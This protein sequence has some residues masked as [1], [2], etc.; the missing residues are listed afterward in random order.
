MPWPLLV[1]AY[2]LLV[3]VC[4]AA[5]IWDVRTGRIP[6]KL[7]YPALL[8]APVLWYAG[9]FLTAGTHEA[10]A[11]SGAS[12]VGLL[13]GGVP[14][15]LLVLTMGLGGGDMKLMAAVG[16]LS[17]SWPV[18]LCTTVYALGVAVIMALG[19]MVRHKIVR[20]TLARVFSAALLA[21]TQT[22][23]NIPD[24][25]PRVPFAVAVAVGAAL[26]GAEQMLGLNT[27]WRPFF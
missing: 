16:A 23:A 10:A 6:N 22:P 5:A 12:V 25:S 7:T 9:G 3:G 20:R 19:L 4:L 21:P 15:M 27:P 24:D 8:A 18:V 13:A 2:L 1:T 11:W 17:A 26:A 14:F